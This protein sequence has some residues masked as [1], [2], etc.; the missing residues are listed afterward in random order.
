MTV[1]R[2]RLRRNV[3]HQ[4][5]PCLPQFCCYIASASSL[6]CCLSC[7]RRKA[8]CPP[9]SRPRCF[10]PLAALCSLPPLS[11]CCLL[12]SC[13]LT[14]RETFVPLRPALSAALGSLALPPRSPF[15]LLRSCVSAALCYLEPLHN[16][17]SALWRCLV[18][19]SSASA[20]AA[21]AQAPSVAA[22]APAAVLVPRLPFVIL[23]RVYRLPVVLAPPLY[24]ALVLDRSLFICVPS[25]C[26]FLLS[27][28]K[29]PRQS[30]SYL[31]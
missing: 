29:M 23:C 18:S 30:Q 21:A 13:A 28:P 9:L 5:L 31:G 25:S 22:S 7:L 14:F 8:P 15:A 20:S 12:F 16:R 17:R 11:V 6:I 4:L 24:C 19:R 2:Q 3:H 1:Q 26:S 10:G 27:C